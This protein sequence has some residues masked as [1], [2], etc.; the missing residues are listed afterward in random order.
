MFCPHKCININ[1]V[2]SLF[3]CKPSYSIQ[4]N[5][6]WTRMRR[7]KMRSLRMNA[8]ST[9]SSVSWFTADKPAGVTI[10]RTFCTGWSVVELA[11]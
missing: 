8:P 7:K 11:R 9:T 3:S 10:S 2:L 5:G 4:V 1:I 6:Y